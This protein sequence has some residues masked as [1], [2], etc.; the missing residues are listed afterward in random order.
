VTGDGWEPD[1]PLSKLW[2]DLFAATPKEDCPAC[3][4]AGIMSHV[5][6]SE[7]LWSMVC[8]CCNGDGEV[9]IT[10]ERKGAR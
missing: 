5:G 9:R 6:E 8:P 3:D 10:P 7:V 2:E 1:L 4:G